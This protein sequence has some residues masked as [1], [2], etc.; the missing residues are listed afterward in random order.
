MYGFLLQIFSFLVLVV[1]AQENPKIEIH[2]QYGVIGLE[3]YQD[4]API[5]TKNFLKYIDEYRYTDA[6]FYRVVKEENQPESD[7]KIEVIQGGLYEDDH[8]MFLAPI[9]HESTS[10]TGIH[11]LDGTISMARYEPGTATFEFFI[12]VGDQPSLDHGGNRNSDGEGF[13]AFGK[14]IYGMDVVN[15]IHQLPD[16]MQYL[17][18]RI[19]IDTMV[20]VK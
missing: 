19:K 7:V 9:E 1:V 20:I 13:A 12:C 16:S 2:T 10:L 15:T 6:T 14:V 5:T 8:P 17:V 3:L 18:P 11:H 4:K